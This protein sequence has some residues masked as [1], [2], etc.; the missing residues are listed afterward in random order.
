MKTTLLAI[1]LTLTIS[2][3]ADARDRIRIVGSSTVYPFSTYIAEQ[4]GRKTSFKTPIVE[5]T[6]TGAGFKLFCAG[7]GLDTADVANASRRLKPEELL[8]CYK[9]SVKEIAEIK[10]GYDG[11]VVANAK[12][13]KQFNLSVKDLFLALAKKVP[14]KQDPKKLV[15]NFYKNWKEINPEFPDQ[16]IEVYGPPSTSGTRDSFAELVMEGGCWHLEAFEV[17]Y[18]D[19]DARKKACHLIREDGAYIDS[20]ENDNLIVQKLASNKTALGIF[21]YSF[22]EE[23]K[24]TVKAAAISGV[25]PSHETIA[26]GSYLVSRPLYVYV[27]RS[28]IGKVPGIEEFIKEHVS[29]DAIAPFGYLEERGLIP[30]EENELKQVQKNAVEGKLLENLAEQEQSNSAARTPARTEPAAGSKAAA[31][32]AK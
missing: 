1:L 2:T 8:E 20:G 6:G 28:H 7:N 17:N 16:K 25:E 18:A 12:D 23:N 32:P 10:I 15:D 29:D 27:K 9:N 19:K 24:N 5:A 14:S 13:S 11:I 21:G 4:Y 30:L 26:D 3:A 31:Q 22:L